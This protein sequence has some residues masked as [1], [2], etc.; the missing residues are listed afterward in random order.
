MFVVCSPQDICFP[1]ARV[2]YLPDVQRR[3]LSCELAELKHAVSSPPTPKADG[4]MQECRPF[5][6]VYR[7]PC[8]VYR[9]RSLYSRFS[10]DGS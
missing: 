7:V 10:G 4:S 8:T 1:P 2:Q 5:E 6:P 3:W 9:W